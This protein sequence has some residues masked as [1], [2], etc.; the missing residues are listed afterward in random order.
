MKQVRY[1]VR[2]ISRKPLVLMGGKYRFHYAEEANMRY[3][4]P[5]EDYEHE[6]YQIHISAGNIEVLRRVPRLVKEEAPVEEV[7]PEP[8]PLEEEVD[9]TITPIEV[10]EEVVEEIAEESEEIIE[11][12]EPVV[13][14]DYDTKRF[15]S[16]KKIAR[17]REIDI[18]GLKKKAD[19][20]EKLREW[21]LDNK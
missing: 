4:I 3:W 1:L 16:L 8:Q 5:E 15:N 6:D 20:I 21:D 17:E 18:T 11:E 14:D 13:S 10:E 12:D 19:I 9:E 7:Q 2:N